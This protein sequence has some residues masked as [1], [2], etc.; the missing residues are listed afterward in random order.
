MSEPTPLVPT[1]VKDPVEELIGTD[2]NGTLYVRGRIPLN[3]IYWATPETARALAARYGAQ[4]IALVPFFPEKNYRETF[5]PSFMMF[6]R[7]PDGLIMNAGMLADQFRRNPEDQFPG[8]A[9][10]YVRDLIA[11]AEAMK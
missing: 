9:D 11:G 4:A 10:R 5:D 8:L 1:F 7:F 2:L 6:L 3:F